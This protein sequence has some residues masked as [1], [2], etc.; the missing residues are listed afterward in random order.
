NFVRHPGREV[1]AIID[2]AVGVD[3]VFEQ[4]TKPAA[5]VLDGFRPDGA[6][7][8]AEVFAA[9]SFARDAD[10]GPVDGRS[11]VRIGRAPAVSVDFAID[12]AIVLVAYI[13]LAD[14]VRIGRDGT[15]VVLV[16]VQIRAQ[17]VVQ[18]TH[19][20]FEEPFLNLRIEELFESSQVL[21]ANV[22]LFRR[23]KK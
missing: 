3:G 1:R 10:E 8:R 4:I 23:R 2:A 16:N 22:A 7:Q 15:E 9:D 17:S 19:L 6:D 5:D 11:A 21:L 12:P 14:L 20:W 18:R 13:F